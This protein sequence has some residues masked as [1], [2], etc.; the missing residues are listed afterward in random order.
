M[1]TAK[2]IDTHCHLDFDAFDDDR[3]EVIHRAIAK[4]ISHIIIPATQKTNWRAIHDLCENS[5]TLSPCYGFHPYWAN[6]PN[7]SDIDE[8]ETWVNINPCVGIGECGLDYREGQI[9]RKIQLKLFEAQL[10]IA[11]NNKLPIVIHSINATEDIINLLKKYPDIKGKM[12]SYSGSYQQAQQL[13]E[14]DFYISFGGTIT[15]ENATKHRATASRIPL[16]HLMIESN[17]PDQPDSSHQDERNEPSYIVNV[18]QCLSDLRV[19]GI[20]AITEQTTLNAKRLFY[21]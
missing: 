20:D 21:I 3:D 19:E 8:L 5:Q 12:H 16:T 6:E 13:I 11:A 4:N 17:S 18:L 7:N 14:R 15:Y 1:I 2:I 10:G 9:E